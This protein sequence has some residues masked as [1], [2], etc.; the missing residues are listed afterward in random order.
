MRLLLLRPKPD[1]ETIG[2]QHVMIVEPLELEVIAAC[3]PPEHSV[4]IVDMILERRPLERVLRSA[5]PDVLCVTGYITDVPGIRAACALAKRLNPV[6][7][8]VVGGVHCEVCPADLDDPAIDFRVVRN[9]TTV[10]APLLAHIEGRGTLPAGV[11]LPGVAVERASLPEYDFTFPRPRRD[12][13]ARYRRHYFYIFHR[14]IALIKTAFG[15]PHRCRFCFCRAITDGRYVR[16]PLD[17]VVE[18]LAEIQEREIYIVDDDFFADRQHVTAFV[19]AVRARGIRRRYLVYGRADFIARHPDAVAAFRAVGLRT[20]IVGIESFSD[21]ELDEFDKGIDAETNRAALRVLHDLG[22]DVY[23]TIIVSP[24]WREADF[25]DCGRELRALGVRYVNLQ[26]LTPLPGTG[27]AAPLTD[28]VIDRADFTRWDL[29]H[30]S[31]RPRHM[32]VAD[33]YRRIMQLYDEVLFQ[34]A[35]LL[36]HVRRYR[37]DQCWRLAVGSYRVR[38]QYRRKLR[39]AERAAR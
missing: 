27:V 34:P 14:R 17:D 13:T 28:L 18:E 39:E 29:A 19:D 16:R 26:P 15:C 22:V 10:F 1:P 25:A 37:V 3:V 21:V 20:V 24:S 2:L 5:S 7:R 31:I 35:A 38:R 32:S 8:T 11:L 6:T 23:A 33:F 36:D 12:L 4:V 9:A 30:V